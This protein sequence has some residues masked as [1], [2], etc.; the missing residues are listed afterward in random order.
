[1]SES[2]SGSESESESESVE[3]AEDEAAPELPFRFNHNAML[4]GI[5]YFQDSENLDCLMRR[6][7]EV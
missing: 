5:S 2:E 7:T 4:P 6:V 1:M 3:E